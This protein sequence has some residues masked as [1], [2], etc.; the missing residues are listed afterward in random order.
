M[1]QL[2]AKLRKGKK[3]GGF[4]ERLD[5]PDEDLTLDYI[6]DNVV[7][8]GSVN[9]VVDGIL[10]LARKDRRLRHIA[11]LRQGL[12]RSGAVAPVHG[13]DGREGHARR[14]CR[15]RQPGRG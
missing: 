4:K 14:Q 8:R 2:T 12:G 6:F 10:A 15:D 3:L 9:R 7:I 1:N 13:A 5:M 11:L